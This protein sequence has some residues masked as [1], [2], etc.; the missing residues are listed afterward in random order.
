MMNRRHFLRAARWL[1]IG[2]V[3]GAPLLSGCSEFEAAA[4]VWVAAVEAIAK[5]AQLVVPQLAAVGLTGQTATNVTN[6]IAQIV[7]A[8][9]VIGSA[10]TQSQGTSTL[11]AIEIYVNDLAPLI[12]PFLPLVPGGTIIGVIV[13]AL[14]EIEVA[15]NFVASL[16]TPVAKQVAATAAPAPASFSLFG[17]SPA[18]NPA[19]PNINRLLNLA[20]QG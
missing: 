12:L 15:V 17:P 18:A 2:A 6:I 16:L 13:A 8:A 10:S 14:P 11:T 1:P 20:G 19:T 7:A 9:G 4:P 3:V 5:E